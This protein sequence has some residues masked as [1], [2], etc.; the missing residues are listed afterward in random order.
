MIKA[1]LLVLDP[2]ATWDGIVAAKR[3]WPAI[4]LGYLLPL[5]L[6]G[7]LAEGYGMVHWGKPH[8]IVSLMKQFSISTALIFQIIQL[9]LFTRVV[10]LGAKIIKG[11]GETFHGRNTFN[12]A[13][14]VTAFGLGPV[15]TL[16]ILDI[17]PSVS[18]WLY[19]A[20]WIAGI[21]MMM[22]I[23]YHGVPKV[24]LPDPPHAFG[25]YLTTTLL[26]AMISGLVR[27]L[28]F[29]YVE[30]KF[31]KLDMLMAKIIE[32]LPI[33]QALDRHHF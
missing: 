18:G 7:A 25:L 13:F 21:L 31:V 10:F 6:I 22:A 1:F 5:W 23:L 9:V 20:L 30:G 11:L 4:L 16:H 15:F 28:T 29:C 17:F 2:A 27:F 12:Q 24:M 19:W 26:L 32:H 8:G 3:K 33:L 14:T